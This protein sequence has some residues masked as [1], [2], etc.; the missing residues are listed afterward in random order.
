MPQPR[1]WERI[2]DRNRWWVSFVH[3]LV[4]RSETSLVLMLIAPWRIRLARLPVIGTR[5]CWPMW[6]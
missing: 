1:Q 4:I 2:T 3:S 5:T 6:P